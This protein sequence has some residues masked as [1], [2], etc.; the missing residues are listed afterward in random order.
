[1]RLGRIKVAPILLCALP[2]LPCLVVVGGR[3]LDVD[4]E[5]AQAWAV[6]RCRAA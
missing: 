6:R 1:M 2:P 4:R 3:S 5:R